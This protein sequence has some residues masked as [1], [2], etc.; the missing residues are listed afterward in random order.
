MADKQIAGVT[1][2]LTEDGYFTDPKNWTKD[3]AIEMAKED[4]L[5]LTDQH[6]KLLEFIRAKFLAGEPLT[7]RSIGKSGIVD[8]KGFYQLFP[9]APLKKASKYAGISKPASCV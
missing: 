7:I 8:I 3:I 2:H 9:G 4:G 5:E 1:I 6:I